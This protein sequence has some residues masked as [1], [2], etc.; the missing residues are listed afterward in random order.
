MKR[1]AVP[2]WLRDEKKPCARNAALLKEYSSSTMDY[3]QN[4]SDWGTGDKEIR[5]KIKSFEEAKNAMKEENELPKAYKK[6]MS[7]AWRKRPA[8]C[9]TTRKAVMLL[10]ENCDRSTATKCEGILKWLDAQEGSS[11]LEAYFP[12]A[13]GFVL[14]IDQSSKMEAM[15]RRLGKEI[16]ERTIQRQFYKAIDPFG[17]NDAIQTG[18]A[19]KGKTKKEEEEESEEESD[20]ESE[21]EEWEEWEAPAAVA[22]EQERRRDALFGSDSEEEAQSGAEET[23]EAEEEEEEPVKKPRW[24]KAIFGSDSEEEEW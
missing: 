21:E 18:T 14:E 8:D 16:D 11:E 4:L 7:E 19:A 24:H 2:E 23:E 5:K 17:K 12:G 13:G 3:F 10:K 1:P 20:E 9:S 15:R 22:K 6:V